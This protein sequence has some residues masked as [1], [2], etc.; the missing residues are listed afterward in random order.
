ME[1]LTVAAKETDYLIVGAG[2]M[3]IAFADELF[4]LKPNVKLTIIDRRAKAGGH[5]NNAY[6]FVRLHQPAAFYGVNSLKLGNGGTDLSSQSELLSYYEKVMDKFK[7]SGRVEFLGQHN[8]LGNGRVADLL[9]P[10]H[11]I[12]YKI[13]ERLVDASYMKVEVPSTHAPKYTID[14]GVTLMPLNE[15]PHQYNQWEQFYIIGSG[16]TGM[17]AVLFLLAKEI[18]ANNIYWVTPND[19]WL[20]NRAHI[21]VGTVAKETLQHA[22][23][24]K[25]AARVEDIFLKMEKTGGIFRLDESILPTK[26]RCATVSPDELTQ[27]RRIKNVIRKGRVNRITNSEIQL[28][29]GNIPYSKKTLFV[30]CSANGLAKRSRTPIFSTDKITLQSIMFCQQ[31]FSAATIARLALTNISDEKRN[32]I[33]PVPHPEFKEDWPSALSTSLDN[34]LLVHRYF[35]MWMFRARLNFMSHEPMIKYFSYAAKAMFLSSAVKKAAKRMDSM[36]EV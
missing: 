31:V 20:F 23:C 3:G 4:T 1:N 12:T 32:Q 8:Y 11:I 21:Q 17:D 30:D 5:W 7:A 24:V 15:L 34:L 16:K 35:P 13:N 28:Q 19:A 18:P 10:D 22:K 6:P 14:D 29:Q 33:I 9:N 2:A 27:L 25:D 26:W 36:Q